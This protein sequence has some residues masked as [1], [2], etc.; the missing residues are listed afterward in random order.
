[1][2]KPWLVVNGYQ[3]IVGSTTYDGSTNQLFRG[4]RPSTG[5]DLGYVE[6]RPLDWPRSRVSLNCFEKIKLEVV[7]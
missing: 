4:T 6:L 7:E 1:M 5:K 2:P 3:Q